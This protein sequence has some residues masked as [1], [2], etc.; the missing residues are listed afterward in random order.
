MPS[1][2]LACFTM[3]SSL[4]LAAPPLTLAQCT[5]VVDQRQIPTEQDAEK[6]RQLRSRLERILNVAHSENRLSWRRGM[7]G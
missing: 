7:G 2:S 1:R 6:S 3:S 4:Q 5:Q